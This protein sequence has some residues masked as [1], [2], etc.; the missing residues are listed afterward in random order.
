MSWSS[1]R[2]GAAS[3]RRAE[4]SR[5]AICSIGICACISDSLMLRGTCGSS[6]TKPNSMSTMSMAA[7]SSCVLRCRDKQGVTAAAEG[8]PRIV[9]SSEAMKRLLSTAGVSSALFPDAVASVPGRRSDRCAMGAI[10]AGG[11]VHPF[12]ARAGAARGRAADRPAG[13]SGAIHLIVAVLTQA[14]EQDGWRGG[15]WPEKGIIL[16]F[17]GCCHGCVSS[18]RA[19]RAVR[20]GRAPGLFREKWRL[21]YQRG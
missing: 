17:V 20:Y 10:D 15:E 9:S 14:R 13:P 3:R 4:V 12:P 16:P 19:A 7:F 18:Y 5:I 1:R 2:A 11:K 8:V 6:S 21:A